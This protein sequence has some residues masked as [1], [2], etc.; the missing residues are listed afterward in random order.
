MMKYLEGE[1]SPGGIENGA[2]QGVLQNKVTPVFAFV[3]TT[4]LT[5]FAGYVVDYH[6]P[7]GCS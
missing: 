4:K 1:R 5:T 2:A 6:H 3:I 7:P